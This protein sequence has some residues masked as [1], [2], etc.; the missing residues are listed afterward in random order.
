VKER[1]RPKAKAKTRTISPT[2]K[3]VLSFII[4]FSFVAV[5]Y[6]ATLISPKPIVI[7][8]FDVLNCQKIKVASSATTTVMSCPFDGMEVHFRN[9]YVPNT[10][11]VI[12]DSMRQTLNVY[13]GYNYTFRI[14]ESEAKWLPVVLCLTKEFHGLDENDTI[15]EISGQLFYY[16]ND[17]LKDWLPYLYVKDMT[18]IIHPIKTAQV[19]VAKDLYF[20]SEPTPVDRD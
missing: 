19:N 15:S 17:Q 20:S 10:E 8:N 9:V 13:R 7:E 18:S 4:L 6:S 14:R 5:I 11:H 16:Y 3:L 1:R 2:L 12:E